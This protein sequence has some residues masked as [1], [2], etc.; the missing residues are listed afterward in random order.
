MA[1]SSLMPITEKLNF[2]TRRVDTGT[3]VAVSG[4]SR[5][6]LDVKIHMARRVL[7]SMNRIIV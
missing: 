6:G 4:T 7:D 3:D 1:T 2:I 5:L